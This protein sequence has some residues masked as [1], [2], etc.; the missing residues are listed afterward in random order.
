MQDEKVSDR[1]KKEEGEETMP[2]Q[3][4]G[5]VNIFYEEFGTGIPVLFLHSGYSRGI[6]AFSGQIQPFYAAGYHCYYPDFRGHGRTLC[7][8]LTWDSG[9]LAEDMIAFL[10]HMGIEQAHLIGYS[11]GGGVAYYMAAR[12][13]ERVKS[14]ITIG[15]GGVIDS[16]G[17]ADFEPEALIQQNATDFI[18]NV[19]S[20]H[21]QAHKG[22]WQEYCHQEVRDWKNHPNLQEAE[23]KRITM[24]MLL[25]AGEHDGFA[26]KER[27][28]NIKKV[29][30]QAEIFIVEGCGHRPHFPGEQAKLVNDRMF[31]FLRKQVSV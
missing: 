30:P 7:D 24:P 20:L 1:L 5:N 19:K 18:D 25:I 28:E 14:V 6:L 29:C 2:Y 31:A 16:A 12:Y 9:Q 22:N 23:W 8:D 4:T 3:Q 17:A 15:N 21:A 11:T 10:D 26:T 13:P 27:L